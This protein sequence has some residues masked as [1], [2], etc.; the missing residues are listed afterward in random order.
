METMLGR[1]KVKNPPKKRIRRETRAK[2]K[3]KGSPTLFSW[4]KIQVLKIFF[5][6]HKM[7]L[8]SQK[9]ISSLFSRI[10]KTKTIFLT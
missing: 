10:K 2:G 3:K 7:L 5:L 6:N 8:L 9:K 4:Y 1:Q